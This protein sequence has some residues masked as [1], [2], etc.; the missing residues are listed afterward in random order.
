MKLMLLSW[1]SKV[2]FP[3]KILVSFHPQSL[4]VL[5][6][7]KPL[8]STLSHVLKKMNWIK[9]ILKHFSLSGVSKIKKGCKRVTTW[10]STILSSWGESSM[11][12][13]SRNKNPGLLVLFP[14]SFVKNGNLKCRQIFRKTK[15]KRF[16]DSVSIVTKRRI[17]LSYVLANAQD[18]QSL[19][20]FYV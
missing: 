14:I 15:K 10:N 16:A 4:L 20:T 18:H 2:T 7:T 6:K 1:T 5:N 19:S 11:L 3:M 8:P 9:R 17:I 12:L 13:S